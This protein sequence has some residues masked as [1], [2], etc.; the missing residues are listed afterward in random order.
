[1]KDFLLRPIVQVGRDQDST[2]QHSISKQGG[3]IINIK[4][5][6]E[7]REPAIGSFAPVNG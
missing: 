1:M 7:E 5:T 6:K 4:P 3:T 2:K